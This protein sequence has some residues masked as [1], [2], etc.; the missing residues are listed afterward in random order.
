PIHYVNPCRRGPR[1]YDDP[2]ITGCSGIGRSHRAW[3]D[4]AITWHKQDAP[5]VWHVEGRH[6]LP[7]LLRCQPLD[8]V[9][10]GG[11]GFDTGM[12]AWDMLFCKGNAQA[13]MLVKV[14]GIAGM[15]RKVFKERQTVA[16]EG[17]EMLVGWEIRRL[18][19]RKRGGPAGNRSAVQEHNVLVPCGCQLEGRTGAQNPGTDNDNLG[20]AWDHMRFLTRQDEMQTDWSQM[21]VW[22]RCISIW[23]S[24]CAAKLSSIVCTLRE[25]PAEPAVPRHPRDASQARRS[26]S[27]AKR[28]CK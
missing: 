12:E 15:R 3:L 25:A 11:G 17:E 10:E 6:Q 9:A 24:T 5:G 8:R 7:G 13:A 2:S 27:L 28:P 26:A 21:M 16:G 18:T 1:T 19:S 23:A 4:I 20:C 22:R 14:D